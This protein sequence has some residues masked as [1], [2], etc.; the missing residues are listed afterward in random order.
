MSKNTLGPVLGVAILACQVACVQTAHIEKND[1]TLTQLNVALFPYVPNQKW[2]SH[3]IEKAW[4]KRRPEVK[5][6]FVWDWDKWDGGYDFEPSSEFDVVGMDAIF[7]HDYVAMNLV[8]PL[9]SGILD[10]DYYTFALRAGEVSRV[11]YGVPYLVCQPVLFTRHKDEQLRNI[12]TVNRLYDV[13]GDGD[14]LTIRP[15]GQIGLLSTELSSGTTS[16]ALY[17]DALAD[18]EPGQT[19]LS[20]PSLDDLDK[21]ALEAVIMLKEMMGD[22]QAAWKNY[23]SHRAKWFA[24]GLGRALYGYTERLGRM[25]ANA[26]E[27]LDVQ[28][29]E[30]GPHGENLFYVDVLAIPAGVENDRRELAEELIQLIASPEIIA[31]IMV[32]RGDVPQYL[33]PARQSALERLKKDD[34][35]PFYIEF[36]PLLET[37]DDAIPI[38]LDEGSRQTLESVK[39]H[40]KARILQGELHN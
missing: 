35:A 31:E 9:D 4:E 32:P 23:E 1:D 21:D 13:L 17:I 30:F 28:S 2:T 37:A 33:L 40:L 25:P 7:L 10:D 3:V 22:E 15:D 5:L 38:A 6:N 18:V 39:D 34:F 16:V 20:V 26:Y 8:A 36:A 24:M 19:P 27:N 11:Q 12:T 29:L 14:D